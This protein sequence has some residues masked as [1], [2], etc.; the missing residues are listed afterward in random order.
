MMQ[1]ARTEAE[2][3]NLYKRVIDEFGSKVPREL[4]D[5]TL[6][7]KPPEYFADIA[8][9]L[10]TRLALYTSTDTQSPLPLAP[11]DD[12]AEAARPREAD[13]NTAANATTSTVQRTAMQSSGTRPTL[14]VIP[15][16]DH[17][18][19]HVNLDLI[20]RPAPYMANPHQPATLPE[21][22]ASKRRGRGRPIGARQPKPP[23][24]PPN[25]P[26]DLDVSMETHAIARPKRPRGGIFGVYASTKFNSRQ[27]KRQF[28]L[29][30]SVVRLYEPWSPSSAQSRPSIVTVA[31]E[32]GTWALASFVPPSLDDENANDDDELLSERTDVP[33][34]QLEHRIED[35]DA[36]Q[37]G[38]SNSG[39]LVQ[40]VESRR[41]CRVHRQ[42]IFV[43]VDHFVNT[44]GTI[45]LQI[46]EQSA[47]SS[48]QYLI[49]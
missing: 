47:A 9:R 37:G 29:V 21:T 22:P 23:G 15:N 7:H 33:D 26:P 4:E 1:R 46:H 2:A 42:R 49:V 43:G 14:L 11:S 24:P 28:A 12:A 10:R 30:A 25:Q 8:H 38:D 32:D 6:K 34:R 5:R 20:G 45:S 16:R 35:Q 3:A 13:A 31:L 39:V 41:Q 36:S 27:S 17:P 18:P 48:V 40:L 44:A 19:F